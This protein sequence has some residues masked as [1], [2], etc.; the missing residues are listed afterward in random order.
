MRVQKILVLFLPLLFVAPGLEASDVSGAHQVSRK[1][2]QIDRDEEGFWATNTN[3][4]IP[5]QPFRLAIG[6]SLG[7]SLPFFFLRDTVVVS[8]LTGV[9]ERRLDDGGLVLEMGREVPHAP[10]AMTRKPD[11]VGWAWAQR[12]F[13]AERAGVW[14]ASHIASAAGPAD[15]EFL[16]A[17]PD[18]ANESND[19]VRYFRERGF[20]YW[21]VEFSADGMWLW[22][23]G[24]AAGVLWNLS[25]ATARQ[26]IMKRPGYLLGNGALCVA[27]RSC[28]ISANGRLLG[29]AVA[30]ME[31]ENVFLYSTET[32]T[33]TWAWVR[34]CSGLANPSVPSH[35]AVRFSPDSKFFF[36]FREYRYGRQK[37]CPM[38]VVDVESGEVAD[39]GMARSSIDGVFGYNES[40][41]ILVTRGRDGV[42]ECWDW[43]ARRRLCEF[44][45][46]A[47]QIQDIAV[48]PDGKIVAVAVE[49][50]I[51][52]LDVATRKPVGGDV[53]EHPKVKRIRFANDNRH[54]ASLGADGELRVW[55]LDFM[56]QIDPL[57]VAPQYDGQS[58]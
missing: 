2:S 18:E 32:G 11:L 39:L 51:H 13:D 38:L 28:A 53:Y 55:T 14:V 36:V 15:R 57:K 44:D 23:Q 12:Q 4:R 58:F 8:E 16:N 49:K 45:M 48:S 1:G 24:E 35:G 7:I 40:C 27:E 25:G 50:K 17:T 42:I 9:A 19:S 20:D 22:C 41:S 6:D 21:R 33:R 29:H 3:W 10:A 43:R 56:E 30:G 54:F 34:D 37:A 31:F 5:P 47:G 26:V 52:F 46:R